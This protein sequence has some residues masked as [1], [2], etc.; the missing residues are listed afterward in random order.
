MEPLDRL[1]AMLERFAVRAQQ[2]HLGR[3]CD[4]R[5]FEALPGRG[6]LHIL[7]EG[8]L[9]ITEQKDRAPRVVSE[10]SLLLYPRPHEHTFHASPQPGVDLACA[11]LEF[12][13]GDGHPLVQA[14]PDI[15]TVP[16]AEVPGL[17]GSLELLS[18]EIEEFRCGHRHVVD[19]LFEIILLKLLRWL[20]DHPNE[21]GLPPGLFGGLADPQIARAL[22]AMHEHPAEAWSLDSLGRTASMSR[23]A[24]AARFR[25]LVGT[26]P[27]DYLT[28][29]RMTVG[30]HLLRRGYAVGYVAAE[31]G[32]TSSS[33]SRVF[34][35]REGVSPRVWAASSPTPIA[36]DL[37][38][39]AE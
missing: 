11:T 9:S 15:V 6:F 1:D 26:T 13:G 32:Y 20:L 34:A 31:L 5:R 24:F 14:L 30:R 39:P 29:W 16:I 12:E 28:A 36:A 33:F 23:S 4:I 7:R 19:R 10:P 3:L 18:T 35:Q 22:A 37:R 21:I 38:T 8:E 27:H 2:F 17:E 25:E